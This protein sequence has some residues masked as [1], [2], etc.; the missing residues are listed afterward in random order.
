MASNDDLDY[1][2]AFFVHSHSE[3]DQLHKISSA[4][5]WRTAVWVAVPLSNVSNDSSSAVLCLCDS[6]WHSGNAALKR[7]GR[8][9][10][11]GWRRERI[12]NDEQVLREV[13]V[14]KED[15]PRLVGKTIAAQ[16]MQMF[17]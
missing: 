5:L 1:R 12:Y 3:L 6:L 16:S 14:T 4:W 13:V 17:V 8:T 9:L 2:K 11:V 10:T 7:S 15:A